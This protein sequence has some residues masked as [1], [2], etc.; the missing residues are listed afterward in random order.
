ME[1]L[2]NPYVTVAV[3][4]ACAVIFYLSSTTGFFGKFMNRFF[5][6]TQNPATSFPCYMG[7]DIALMI[8]AGVIGLIFIGI[9]FFDL[10]EMFKG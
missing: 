4:V 5:P 10:Y 6:C 3:I 8:I 9:L 7:F 2:R 1:L